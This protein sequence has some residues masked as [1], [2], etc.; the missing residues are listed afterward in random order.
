M[1]VIKINRN[2]S[3]WNLH[4]HS[5]F[6]ANDALPSV[7]DMVKTVKGYKQPALGL[8]DHGNM[9]GTVQL[10]KECTNAGIKPFPGTELYVV[11]DRG[12]K[13]AK[14]HHMC[15]VAFNNDG[16]KNLVNLNTT[17]NNNFYH[18]PLLDH[19]DFASLSEEGML[20]GLAFTSGCFFGFIAQAIENGSEQQAI[21]LMKT[22]DGWFD[23]FYVELQNH[24]IQHDDGNDDNFIAD[25]LHEI[26]KGLGIPAVLTQDAHYC[27]ASDKGTHET[28]KRL[29]SF[30]PD[31]D[32]AVFPGDGFHL[33]NRSWFESHHEGSRLAYGKEGLDD[34]LSLHDLTIPQLD[35]YS[36]NIPFTVPHPQ[37]ELERICTR[38]LKK[39]GLS[40]SYLARMKDELEIVSDTGMAGYLLLVS[41]VTDWCKDNRVFYQA[42][43]SASGSI[44]CWLLDITQIDP[45]KYKLRFERFISRDRTKPPDI[46]LDVEHTNRIALIEWLKTR[47]SVHQI[48]TWMTHSLHGDEDG[49]TKGSLRVK[50]YT[51][52][53]AAGED[54]HEWKN[55]PQSDKDELHRLAEMSP[56]SG[57]GTHAAGLVVTTNDKQF[58][59]VVPMMKVASSGTFVTQYDMGDVESLGFVKL[60]VL[61]LKVLT[62]LNTCM[63]NLGRDVLEGLSWIPNTDAKTYKMIAKGE[64]EGVFQLEG[65]TAKMGV[66]ELKPTKLNDV[67]ASMALFRPAAM[68]SGA[69]KSFIKRKH[70]EE[71][72]PERHSIIAENTKDTY[73]I[74]V[75]QEQVI[76]V[77]R[78]LGMNA[79]DLTSFLKAVKASNAD[80]GDAAGVIE[81][82][83]SQLHAMAQ[84]KGMDEDDWDWVWNAIEAFAGYGFNKC[85]SGD[86]VIYM[87]HTGDISAHRAGANK[88]VGTAITVREYYDVFHGSNTPTRKKYRNKKQGLKIAAHKDGRVITDKAIGV[89]WSGVQPVY[90]MKLECGKSI[91][92][93]VNHRH[94]T[95]RGWVEQF[96]ITEDDYVATMGD[97]EH[98]ATPTGGQKNIHNGRKEAYSKLPPY[99]QKCG[100]SEGR[101]EVAHPNHDKQDNSEEN[102]RRLCNSCHKQHDWDTGARKRRWSKGRPIVWSKVVSIEYAGD[103][104]TY[105]VEMEGEDH[106]WVGNGIVTHNSHAAAYGLTS[107]RC[108]YLAKNHPLEFFAAVLSVWA[109]KDKEPQYI[110][111]ARSRGLSIR[112]P[113]VNISGFSYTVDKRGKSIRK[114]LLAIKGVGEKTA[115]SIIENR[116]ENGYES[117]E[118]FAELNKAKVSGCKPYLKDKSMDVGVLGKLDAAGVF[119]GI[120]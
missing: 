120:K 84:E 14:R 48:G 10:Y 4:S 7:A 42:R 72:I 112:K 49:E 12:D 41:Q 34:L 2:D 11:G 67:I 9:G 35:K 23:E 3:Y 20:K 103:E 6:S 114:G 54:I 27:N 76:S 71:D 16:Y 22:Y 91:K 79:D 46:D 75:Y 21:C 31:S 102:I 55:V 89:K 81:S 99:C 101:L 106:S 109:G 18:K 65:W 98:Y 78:D 44:L 64:T 8:T 110:A 51:K 70:K 47:F 13:K 52:K 5:E 33:A 61:G 118:Q 77:L 56:M 60:D 50:Y 69:T 92:A 105:D 25:R 57:Y 115:R 1:C 80:V 37:D 29:V 19:Q 117:M 45:L 108:A 82:Y 15:V 111:A 59:E 96:D 26:S 95:K 62:I 28:L 32:E 36:Y 66:Q 88:N 73:G 58:N 113:D 53:R 63:K 24:N 43:G 38:E 74:L 87:S 83:S 116:P 17:A 68:Q 86:T 104:D 107:Y 119:G 94:L 30:G 100:S 39:R 90:E 93:T 40:K 97:Y 85:T